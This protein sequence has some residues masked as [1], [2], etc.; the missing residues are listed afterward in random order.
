MPAVRVGR[1]VGRAPCGWERR[2]ALVGLSE[3]IAA[4]AAAPAAAAAAAAADRA[5]ERP[6]ECEPRVFILRSLTNRG[7]E[8]TYPPKLIVHQQPRRTGAGV[9]AAPA[10][11][12]QRLRQQRQQLRERLVAYRYV[13]LHAP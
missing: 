7:V 10:L 4:P 6:R 9:A 13:R 8:L 2:A 11:S 1:R 5:V 3:R 12:P